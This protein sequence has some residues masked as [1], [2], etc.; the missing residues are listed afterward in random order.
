M[1]KEQQ[2]TRAQA[3]V[4][5]VLKNLEQDK[6]MGAKLRRADNPA[7][8]YQSWE[9]LARFGINL[10][11]T[12]ERKIFSAVAAAAARAKPKTDGNLR[13][14]KAIA[15]IYSEGNQSEQ[16]QARLRRMLACASAEEACDVLRPLLQLIAA[17]GQALHYGR[18]LNEL[19]YFNEKTKER[20]AQ[21]FF[22]Y[23]QAY[24]AVEE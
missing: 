5:Y 9:Y 14:G 6:G 4:D 3:F 23:S 19:L 7:T 1:S 11:H 21:D 20:W 8:E 16:G 15:G 10:E 18:L 13:L 2:T 17:K 12:R 22:S 24:I